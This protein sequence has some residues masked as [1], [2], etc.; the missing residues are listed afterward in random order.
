[1]TDTTPAAPDGS[2]DDGYTPPDGCGVDL[3]DDLKCEAKGVKEQAD[4]NAKH[5]TELETARKS[6]DTARVAY[7]KARSDAAKPYKELGTQLDKILE[8][9]RCLIDDKNKVKWLNQAFE[10]VKTRLAECPGQSGCYLDDTCDFDD[11]I[12]SPSDEVAGAIKKIEDRVAAA[13]KVFDDLV[14]ESTELPKNVTARQTEVNAIVNEMATDSR[15]VDFK[16]L[17]ARALVAKARRDNLWRGFDDVNDYVDCICRALLCQLKGYDAVSQLTKR[18]AVDTCYAESEAEKCK[19]LREHTD[20][21]VLEEYEKIKASHKP[22]YGGGQQDGGYGAPHGGDYDQ[23]GTG[24]YDGGQQGG[25]YPS[26]G[27]D[28]D[29]GSEG[30]GS[31]GEGPGDY[32]GQQGRDYQPPQGGDYQ[33]PQGG[34]YQPPQGG[35]Y[36]PPQGEG[37]YRGK[38]RPPDQGGPGYPRRGAQSGLRKP[39]T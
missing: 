14:K 5:S 27:D 37:G 29:Y 34:D 3:L 20:V 26:E 8:Q 11:L 7:R 31:S 39:R 1:M 23:Q 28:E 30:Y 22:G 10:V 19:Q 13:K 21:A 35:D 9:L 12:N 33:P 36:E 6:Y 25:D 2:G 16:A 32:G 18:K 4:Y 24:G 17:Y 15:L 38:S